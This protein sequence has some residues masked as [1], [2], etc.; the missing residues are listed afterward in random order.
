MEIADNWG[1]VIFGFFEEQTCWPGG[2][3]AQQQPAHQTPA[4]HLQETSGPLLP[5]AGAAGAAARTGRGH[6][7]LAPEPDRPQRV[8]QSLQ[9]AI[10]ERCV[11]HCCE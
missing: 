10:H 1:D 9:P 8:A 2:S 6:A 11:R 4:R 3:P 7:A 5:A